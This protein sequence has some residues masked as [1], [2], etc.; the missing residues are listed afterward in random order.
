MIIKYLIPILMISISGFAQIHGNPGGPNIYNKAL[1]DDTYI[2]IEGLE[3][4]YAQLNNIQYDNHND[5]RQLIISK[6]LYLDLVDFSQQSFNHHQLQNCCTTKSDLL[7]ELIKDYKVI[8]ELGCYKSIHF[9]NE[10]EILE[11][12]YLYETM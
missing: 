6:Q 12:I 4:R 1:C 3:R 9:E 10:L 2:S 11:K 7:A 5:F 8:I